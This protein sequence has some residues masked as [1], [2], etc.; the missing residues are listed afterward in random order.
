MPSMASR[1]SGIAD[2]VHP[3]LFFTDADLDAIR[4]R[5]ASSLKPQL[6]ALIQDAAAHLDE[7]PPSALTGD[8][9][10]KGDQVQ[11]P[12]LHLILNFSFLALITGEARYREAARRWALSLARMPELVGVLDPAARRCA[13]CGYPEGWA[14]TALAVAYD[15]LYPH[16]DADARAVLQDKIRL[17]SE[18]LDDA[19]FAGEWWTGAYLHHDTWIPLGGLGLGAL[20]IAREVPEAEAWAARAQHELEAALDWLDG[21]GAWPEGPCGWAFALASVVPFWEAYRRRFPGR[22]RA[23]LDSAWLAN[24]WRFRLYSR[25]PDGR[26]LGFGDCRAS[27]GYQ[28][29]GFEG[30]PALRWLAARYRNPYAQW[31]A[32]REWE[33][34]PNPYTAAWEIVFDDPSVGALPPDDLPRG[35]A[36][37]NQAM[38]FLRTGWDRAATVL[39][40]R[41]AALLGR[42]ATSLVSAARLEELDNSTTHVH[43]DGNAFGVWSRGEFAIALAHYGQRETDRQNSLLVDGRGQ[44]TAFDVDHPGRPEGHLTS[45][46]TSEAASLVSAE[47]AGCYPPGLQRFVRR[48]YLIEPGVVFVHDDIAAAAAVEL[49]WRFHVDR[50]AAVDVRSDGFT[51]VLE[52]A[53]TVV[54][55]ASPG[56]LR[57]GTLTDVW[58]RAVTLM[59]PER[60]TQAQLVAVVLPSLP[61]DAAPS[62]ATPTGNAFVLEALGASVVA[63]FAAAPGTLHVPGRLEAD[64]TAAIA[65][66]QGDTRGLLA[67]D[68]TR[69]AVD[70]EVLFTAGGPVTLSYTRRGSTVRV[71]VATPRAVRI[72]LLDAGSRFTVR[73]PAGVSTHER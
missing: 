70:G 36:F 1:S 66:T 55:L 26:F 15:W 8:D 16:L 17:L 35:A 53:R 2:A 54:R 44:Y 45:F 32:E 46:F 13:G 47:A 7:A 20:S 14:L 22:G 41:G 38:A 69:C 31:L 29:T 50:G 59:L 28:T 27:G 52:G 33:T 56:G 43:A 18:V 40:F 42:R 10:A 11:S 21:D 60:T 57:A 39:A 49:E 4:A 24:T 30:A 19:T 68:S 62:I 34:L 5:A 58:N 12:F 63:A 72:D 61:V 48:L 3:S 9:E 23:L 51:S 6:D 37:E 73:A 71:A 25:V 67:V 65:W 64:G